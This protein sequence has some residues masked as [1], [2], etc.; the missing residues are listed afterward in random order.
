MSSRRKG[1][2]NAVPE[3]NKK[4]Q[5][6]ICSDCDK[7]VLE[8]D[9][10]VQC[11]LCNH[12]LHAPC[13][14]VPEEV[15]KVLGSKKGKA[16]KW[17]CSKCE[18]TATGVITEVQRISLKYQDMDKRMKR[19]E[20]QLVTKASEAD[21][22]DIKEDLQTQIDD[23]LSK[24]TF[25][26]I[27]ATLR[28]ATESALRLAMD[29]IDKHI[30]SEDR[31]REIA[32]EEARNVQ[33][34][35]TQESLVKEQIRELVKEEIEK[36]TTETPASTASQSG[37][38]GPGNPVDA[39]ISREVM[40]INSRKD[41]IVIYRLP[42][43]PDTS[44]CTN[45]EQKNTKDQ[46]VLSEILTTVSRQQPGISKCTRIGKATPTKTRPLLVTFKETQAKEHFMDNLR[47]LQ[48]S[49]FHNITISH[50]LTKTQQKEL[51]SLKQEAWKKTEEEKSGDC[52][53]RVM[54]P[55]SN[56]TIRKLKKRPPK[57]TDTTGNKPQAP[58]PEEPT[59]T[60][61]QSTVGV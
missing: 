5:S 49:K 60:A 20:S 57:Q 18:G 16:L 29:Q 58:A 35:G 48:G 47:A 30:P 44:Y 7:P 38:Y 22:K 24:T 51:Q 46:E 10:G 53:F 14:N 55:P 41:N 15:Y 45:G 19:F 26:D 50:D 37:A 40:D 42:E 34:T 36:H 6:D 32:Q 9:Q 52:F 12:W 33:P 17:Y 54:G 4:S 56:W 27:E 43:Q 31:I 3:K 21:L 2:V 61:S 59:D 11:D 25:R 28:Q 39:N 1:S 23:K 13:Q 8:E